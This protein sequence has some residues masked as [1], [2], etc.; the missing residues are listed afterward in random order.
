M[1]IENE[2]NEGI[3]YCKFILQ[4]I[5]NWKIAFHFVPIYYVLLL[6]A[7]GDNIEYNI[8]DCDRETVIK[9]NDGIHNDQDK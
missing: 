3:N 6:N 4:G 5:E 7:D 1:K 2:K 9:R 8:S